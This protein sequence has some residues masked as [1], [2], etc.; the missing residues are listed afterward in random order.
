MMSQV[1]SFFKISNKGLANV[2]AAEVSILQTVQEIHEI[3]NA[4]PNYFLIIDTAA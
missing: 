4:T 1:T 3:S 2:A